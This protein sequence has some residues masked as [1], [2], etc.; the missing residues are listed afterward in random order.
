MKIVDL[1]SFLELPAG[2]VF[3]KY[4]PC[5]FDDLEVKGETWGRD[6]LSD[7]ITYW[8]RCESDVDFHQKMEDAERGESLDL[9]FDCTTKD[10]I[11]DEEQL[12]AVYEGKDVDLLI[13]KLERCKASAYS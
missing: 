6:F 8:S 3:M 12:F 11:F 2:T 13:E 7:N 5:V 9:D 4:E 10:G 1:K